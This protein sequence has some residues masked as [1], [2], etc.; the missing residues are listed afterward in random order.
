MTVPLL[1]GSGPLSASSGSH[2]HV[3]QGYLKFV[4]NFNSLRAKVWRS[5]KMFLLSKHGGV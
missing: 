3:T 2:F 1:P 4:H 5:E